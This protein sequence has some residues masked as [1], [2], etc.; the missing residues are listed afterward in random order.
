MRARAGTY[1]HHHRPAKQNLAYST[2]HNVVAKERMAE[3]MDDGALV[4]LDPQNGEVLAMVGTWNYA[5][6]DY[7]QLNE[8]D[9]SS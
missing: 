7:G 8:A 5:D 2:V 1:P 9:T 4:S 6:P 3:N